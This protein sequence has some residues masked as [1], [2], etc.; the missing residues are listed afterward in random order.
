[1]KDWKSVAAYEVFQNGKLV[2]VTPLEHF[3]VEGTVVN[4]K[5][6]VYAIGADGKRK[7]VN[8]QWIEDPEQ[9]RKMKV[10][11]SQFRNMYNR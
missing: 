8:F 10:R 11:E 7:K 1:M 5:T 2:F 3:T 4:A 6:K 9:Q